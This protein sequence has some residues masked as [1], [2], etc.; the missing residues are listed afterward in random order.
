MKTVNKPG[1]ILVFLML[2]SS[3]V[4]ILAQTSETP[5]PTF[6]LTIQEKPLEAENTPG[7]RMLLVKYTNVS[8]VIQKDRCV[9]TPVANKMVVLR[10]GLPAEKRKT[11]SEN[12]DESQDQGKTNTYRIKV[13]HTEADSCHGVDRGLNPGESVKFIL[14]VSSEY[15]MTVPGTYEITVTRETDRW[16]PEKSVTIKSNTSPSSC[17]SRRPTRRSSPPWRVPCPISNSRHPKRKPGPSMQPHGD[18]NF[19]RDRSRRC[20]DDHGS[21]QRCC[22]QQP[23][24]CALLSG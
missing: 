19:H 18:G 22:D 8:D 23:D 7:T 1:M 12:A 14:W 9:V 21:L 15:D 16:N 10:N 17:P 24:C 6:A 13:H 2:L 3:A 5:A 11:R 20:A 4:A